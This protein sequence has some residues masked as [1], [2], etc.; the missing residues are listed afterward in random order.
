MSNV[1]YISDYLDKKIGG[2]VRELLIDL[3]YGRFEFEYNYNMA[4]DKINVFIYPVTEA[5]HINFSFTIT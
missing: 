5:E 1:V 3:D 4:E 2:Y